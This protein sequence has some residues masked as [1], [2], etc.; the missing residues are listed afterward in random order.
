M[1][2]LIFQLRSKT[3]HSDA[4]LFVIPLQKHFHQ[5]NTLAAAYLSICSSLVC[6]CSAERDFHSSVLMHIEVH[7][8][9]KI[10]QL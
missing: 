4:C 5:E 2:N 7:L 9:I 8:P 6:V 3:G 1:D 10:C